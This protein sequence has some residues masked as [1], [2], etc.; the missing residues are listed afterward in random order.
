MKVKHS[1][2]FTVKSAIDSWDMCSDKK[3]YGAILSFDVICVGSPVIKMLGILSSIRNHKNV[4][5]HGRSPT[6][7][8]ILV[9]I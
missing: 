8:D 4:G 3:K 5:K 7:A 1:G 6:P 2:H 9:D